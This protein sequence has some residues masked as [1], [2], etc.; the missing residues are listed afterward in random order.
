M[1]SQINQYLQQEDI[2]QIQKCF[3]KQCKLFDSFMLS[4]LLPCCQLITSWVLYCK[5]LISLYRYQNM[6]QLY[7]FDNAS[8][9]RAEESYFFCKELQL[10]LLI[11]TFVLN[12]KNIFNIDFRDK[13][14]FLKI[15]RLEIFIEIN[16]W[17]LIKQLMPP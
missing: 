16:M 1:P 13:Y 2:I 3:D 14:Q 10:K 12:N 17:R 7:A 6:K 11:S 15:L 9:I 5:R 8:P 4:N